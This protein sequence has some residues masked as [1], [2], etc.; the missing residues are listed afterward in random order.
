[1]KKIVPILTLCLSALIILLC[2]AALTCA[3]LS[4]NVPAVSII[5]L[6]LSIVGLVGSIMLA[7][8]S[9]LFKKDILCRISFFINLVSLAVAIAAVSVGFSAL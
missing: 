2:T 9:F 7:P 8:L 5:A 4:C 6:P 3:I 1:M